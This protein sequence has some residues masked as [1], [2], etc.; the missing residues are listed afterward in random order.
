MPLRSSINVQVDN[1]PPPPRRR[2]PAPLLFSPSSRVDPLFLPFG[3]TQERLLLIKSHLAPA[4]Q[5]V[6]PFDPPGPPSLFPS[7]PLPWPRLD[8]Q[9]PRSIYF[10]EETW[11]MPTGPG[12]AG[13]SLSAQPLWSVSSSFADFI[14]AVK[15]LFSLAPA[16]N[17][18]TRSARR[19]CLPTFPQAFSFCGFFFSLTA[20]FL[21][22]S[23]VQ[24]QRA[25]RPWLFFAV[26]PVR[27]GRGMLLPLFLLRTKLEGSPFS[28][29]YLHAGSNPISFGL[30][31]PY[32]TML[33]PSLLP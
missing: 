8:A 3:F 5:G 25:I 33:F 22:V 30:F 26:I 7:C 19:P 2:C 24:Q 12:G 23:A 14:F 20:G 29:F 9:G 17:P 4:L 1:R 15:G 32:E 27:R 13:V 28:I 18:R 31:R 6:L 16:N 10:A 11:W 21:P